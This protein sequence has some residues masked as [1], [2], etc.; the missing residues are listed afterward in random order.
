MGDEREPAENSVLPSALVQDDDSS[1]GIIDIEMNMPAAAADPLQIPPEENWY[2]HLPT[3]K[4]LGPIASDTL[5]EW[6]DQARIGVDALVWRNG[7]DQWQVIRDAFSQTQSPAASAEPVISARPDFPDGDRMAP[8]G[9][10]NS[11]FGDWPHRRK[12]RFSATDS[13]CLL[14]MVL[15]LFVRLLFVFFHRKRVF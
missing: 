13:L 14:G 10:P 4:Q 5:R 7:W 1:A 9:L 12:S 6:L 15:L 8:S 11:Q 3:G 2:V